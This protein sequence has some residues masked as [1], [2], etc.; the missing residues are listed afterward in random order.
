MC[1]KASII[2]KVL[3]EK[4]K[5]VF[6]ASNVYRNVFFGAAKP[7]LRDYSC[8]PT[9]AK[10]CLHFSKSDSSSCNLRCITFFNVEVW[11][12]YVASCSYIYSCVTFYSLLQNVASHPKASY[13]RFN[14][15][16]KVYNKWRSRNS[17]ESKGSFQ[18]ESSHNSKVS[19]HPKLTTLTGIVWSGS[20][21]RTSFI[22]KLLKKSS[23]LG[24]H[25]IKKQ[26]RANRL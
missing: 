22:Q 4:I 7:Y 16:I 25:L 3:G 19:P 8:K 23:Q 14:I 11:G 2:I 18:I 17:C 5:P 12:E 10:V 24:D 1:R 20:D 26:H 21:S 15:S 9:T 13:M 6:S